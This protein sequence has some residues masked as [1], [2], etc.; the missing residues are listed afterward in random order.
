M[1][2]CQLAIKH[3]ASG[4]EAVRKDGQIVKNPVTEEI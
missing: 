3:E 1:Q 2:E 4:G